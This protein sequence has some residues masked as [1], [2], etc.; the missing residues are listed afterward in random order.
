MQSWIAFGIKLKISVILKV[1]LCLLAERCKSYGTIQTSKNRTKPLSAYSLQQTQK[2]KGKRFKIHENYCIKAFNDRSCQQ[3]SSFID[4]RM[5][6]Y[7]CNFCMTLISIIAAIMTKPEYLFE[8]LFK[9]WVH[10][11]I[12][13]W[14]Y[15]I[16]GEKQ[17]RTYFGHFMWNVASSCDCDSAYGHRNPC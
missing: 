6:P 10:N 14:I 7:S 4:R 11:P 16:T 3:S 5:Y 2:Y 13:D 8:G 12:D 1:C 15:Q 17:T 9:L